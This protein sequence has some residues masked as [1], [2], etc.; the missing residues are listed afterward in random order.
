M[1]VGL[2]NG[3]A[4]LLWP[5]NPGAF[6][7][8]LALAVVA[9]H[10][11]RLEF[12]KAPVLVFFALSGYWV[13]R[14]WHARYAKC[15]APW[16]TFV[17]SRWWRVA[18]LLLLVSGLSLAAHAWCGDG[19][20]AVI[21]RQPLAQ[22]SAPFTVLGSGQLA[23]RPVGPAWSL[24]IEMQFYMLAPLLM[25]MV[26]RWRPVIV[27]GFGYASFLI[28]LS[29]G[30]G[31]ILPAFLIF[32]LLGMLAAQHDWR[33]LSVLG[34]SGLVLALSMV[35]LAWALPGHEQWL[36]EGG[37]YTAPFNVALALCL[38]PLALASVGL[39]SDPLDRA[40]GGM[41]YLVYLL[42]WP[43]VILLRFGGLGQGAAALGF[44]IMGLLSLF[45]WR[46]FDRPLDRLR[47]GWVAAQV[48]QARCKAGK[49]VTARLISPKGA[50]SIKRDKSES[51]CRL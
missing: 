21:L 14:V 51:E 1:S 33:V 29:F 37:A 34:T 2:I 17:I 4:R 25:A 38:M 12:G 35:A 31:I 41:S 11:T 49:G 9:H 47:A 28:A 32:F 46:W 27:L 15:H 8:W 13:H 43:A 24:D 36:G 5:R 3:A 26:A 7:L 40:M 20:W 18:P 19:D 44:A 30:W 48:G 23:T 39:R 22:M 50:P 6:R 45:L 10:I 16:L 42:H